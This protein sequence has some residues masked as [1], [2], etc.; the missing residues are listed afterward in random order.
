MNRLRLRSAYGKAGVQPGTVAAIQYLNAATYPTESGEAP[1]LRLTSI[2]NPD[3][4]PEVTTEMEAGLDVGFL[5]DRVNVEAT[6]FNKGSKDALFNRPLPPSYGAGA[7]KWENLAQVQ[8]RGFEANIDATVYRVGSHHVR[9]AAERLHHQEQAD[10]RRWR[11]SSDRPGFAKRRRLSAVRS[12]GS[13][14]DFLRRREQRRDHHR[15]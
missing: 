6:F 3:L 7:T 5:N 11:A 2:G 4:K 8:N 13:Q 1:G 10:R 12:L 15:K 9:P 14:A